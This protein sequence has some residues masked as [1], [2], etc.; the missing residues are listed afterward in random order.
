[1]LDQETR[2]AIL[3]L[4]KQKVS[5]RGI[6]TALS[7][8]RRAVRDVIRSGTAEVPRI[9]R[10]EKAEAFADRIRELYAGCK[11]NLVRVHE[12]ILAEGCD[13]SYP[14]LTSFCRRHGIG[15]E[16]KPP[17][18]RYHFGPGQEMQHDT[19]PHDI[20]VGGRK[21]RVQV[22]SLVMCFSRLLFFQYFARFTRF[23]CKVFLTAALR[24]IGGSCQVC[25]I[26]NTHVIVLR[27][28]GKEMVPVP[29][30][31]A[32]GEHFGFTFRAH[33][34]GDANRSAHVERAFHFIENNFEAGRKG[35]DFHDWNRQAIEFC[36]KVNARTKRQLGAS[37]RE[38]FVLEQPKL[39]SLPVWIPPVYRIHQRIVGIE[40]YIRIDSNHYSVPLP[41]GRQVEVR[42]SIER[43]EVY[44][45][46]RVVARHERVEA[47]S[48]KRVT[49]P[50]HRPPRGEGRKAR[51]S[52]EEAAILRLAPEFTDY[53]A[54]LKKHG[55]GQ[56]VRSLRRLLSM[57]RE[58]PREPLV[59]AI[60]EAA[61]YRL[62]DLNRVERM[63]IRRIG[64]D[65]FFLDGGGKDGDE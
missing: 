50:A 34:K 35:E 65:Y 62:L 5:I 8:S 18:G 39:I 53:V 47:P 40:G 9:E 46:P 1:M 37:P 16:R 38:L 59:A 57:I 15:P 11:G 24:S 21:R 13:L 12:E 54:M 51:E 26:D 23:E 3:T 36:D 28:T 29:E 30:M 19:S 52:Q 14:A 32:F 27:G 41:V 4:A 43:I 7:I 61:Q 58:Y 22:A 49:D 63:V 31:E 2:T 64:E 56:R 25:M 48:N 60:Q 33:E 20:E 45:G 6:A 10:P 44:D 42:E 17:A 55:R